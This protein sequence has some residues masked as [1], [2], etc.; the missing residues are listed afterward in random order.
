MNDPILRTWVEIAREVLGSLNRL[1]SSC[2][3]GCREP[4]GL[5]KHGVVQEA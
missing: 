4:T 3:A 2:K 5:Q 1:S